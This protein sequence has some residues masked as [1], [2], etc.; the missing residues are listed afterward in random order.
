MP[1]PVLELNEPS[2]SWAFLRKS[3]PRVMDFW[4][5][6]AVGSAAVAVEA[7]A[8]PQAVSS[9][10]TRRR[11]GRS[12]MVTPAQTKWLAVDG[13]QGEGHDPDGEHNT[14]GDELPSAAL[15]GRRR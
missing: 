9:A 3:V 5:S 11:R 1:G 13:H 12:F 15:E 2:D 4:M 8:K 6:A 7:S 14:R 10:R